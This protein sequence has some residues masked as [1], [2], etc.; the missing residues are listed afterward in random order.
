LRCVAVRCGV[1]QY[2]VVCCSVCL[3]CHT[4]AVW[5]GMIRGL[6]TVKSIVFGAER[7]GW[8]VAGEL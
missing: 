3:T 6:V 4:T 7:Y 1:L 5:G 2:A 8:A